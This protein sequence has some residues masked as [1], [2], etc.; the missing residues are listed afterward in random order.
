MRGYRSDVEND[1]K[2]AQLKRD[3]LNRQ[4]DLIEKIAPEVPEVAIG[5]CTN[6]CD[7]L[8]SFA[9]IFKH[10]SSSQIKTVQWLVLIWMDRS[11]RIAN[12]LVRG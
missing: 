1:L 9:T 4:K 12:Q 5:A 6:I 2:T 11:G 10:V 7:N 3:A 8:D